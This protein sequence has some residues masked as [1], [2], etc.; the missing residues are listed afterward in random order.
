M[1]HSEKRLLTI[2]GIAIFIVVNLF[3]I[4]QVKGLFQKQEKEKLKAQQELKLSEM[5]MDRRSEVQ[6]QMKWLAENEPQPVSK[7]TAESNL[8]DFVTKTATE[9]GLEIKN[10]TSEPT[11]T[12]SVHYHRAKVNLRVTGSEEALY[13]WIDKL[14]VPKDFRGVTSL[15]LSPNKE[16]DTKIDAKLLIEQWFIPMPA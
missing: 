8:M 4:T 11:D 10:P 16:D 5:A 1:S 3:G 6:P 15:E 9:L 12:T 2:F 7:Q 14:Q 13:R